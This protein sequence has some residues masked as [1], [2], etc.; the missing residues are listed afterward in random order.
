MRLIIVRHGDIGSGKDCFIGKTDFSLSK[1]GIKQSL[2]LAKVLSNFKIDRVY[3][4]GLK[5]AKQTAQKIADF[6]N[7]K[8]TTSKDI[9][10]VNFGIFE[11]LNF[12]E[13]KKKFP[14]VYNERLN[15]KWNYRILYGKVTK[16]QK[17]E[18]KDF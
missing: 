9:R 16:M 17:K 4:S 7:S 1:L 6:T 15:D 8:V 13:A 2:Q 12:E 11:C 18:S 10:E 5:R 14:H 3:S